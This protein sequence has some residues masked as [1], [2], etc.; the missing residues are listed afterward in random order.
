MLNEKKDM[1]FKMW[2]VENRVTQRSVARLLGISNTAINRKINGKE[3]FSIEQVRKI[4][5][6]YN[7]SADQLFI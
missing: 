4:C 6:E 2:L 5:R 3:D 1:R 7:V